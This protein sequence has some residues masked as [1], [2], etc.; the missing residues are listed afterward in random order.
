M[1]SRILD[2]KYDI[3][4]C[5]VTGVWGR[6]K[7]LERLSLAACYSALDGMEQ[8]A[9]SL[10][11]KVRSCKLPAKLLFIEFAISKDCQVV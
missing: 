3:Q 8:D 9:I 4:I 7:A 6:C 10:V 1:A 11:G 2:Y 5:C